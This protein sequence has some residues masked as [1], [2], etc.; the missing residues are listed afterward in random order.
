M[1]PSARSRKLRTLAARLRSLAES[2]EDAAGTDDAITQLGQLHATAR[3]M[4]DIRE[5]FA[6]GKG[7]AAAAA[8]ATMTHEQIA[9]YLGVSKPYVQ[10]MVYRG[11]GS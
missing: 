11:R 3:S 1:T 7:A 2:V 10:Q 5:R 9:E 8:K 4:E 6:D